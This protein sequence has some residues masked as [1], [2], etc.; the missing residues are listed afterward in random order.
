[1]KV[2]F[3]PRGKRRAG[4]VAAWWRENRPIAPDLF[5]DELAQ[6]T[7]LLEATPKIG[8]V[9]D[10]KGADVVYRLLLRRTEQHLYYSLDEQDGV[11]MLLTIWGARRGRGPKL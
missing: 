4:A 2:C 1:M 11:I 10:T 8:V 6:A 5:D 9:F 3:S 7:D